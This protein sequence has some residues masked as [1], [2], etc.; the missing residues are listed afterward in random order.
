[1]KSLPFPFKYW[2]IELESKTIENPS[3]SWNFHSFHDFYRQSN[4]TRM[5]NEL[6]L[7]RLKQ[8]VDTW[9]QWRKG[10]SQR[11]DLSRAQLRGAALRRAW[12][13]NVDLSE[14][15][16]SCADLRRARLCNIC[17][18]AAD[19]TEANLSRASLQDAVLKR[20]NFA[21]TSLRWACLIGADLSGANLAGANLTGADLTNTDLS[22]ANLT[23]AELTG[24]DLSG[25]SL[26]DVQACGTNFQGAIFTGACLEDWKID[27]ATQLDELIGDY[28]YL[29]SGRQRRFPSNGSLGLGEIGQR[30]QK[31]LGKS[32]PLGT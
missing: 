32:E 10:N 6:Y 14:A 7:A 26:I 3:F 24:A 22:G 23:G 9:N 20:A 31:L 8:D 19:F 4:L 1:M 29:E 13:N 21:K 11:L 15:N 18:I 25:A 2:T 12:L 5:E 17:A 28:V 27:K 16:L 30:L